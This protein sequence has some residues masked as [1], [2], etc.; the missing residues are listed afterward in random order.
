VTGP[1]HHS[2]GLTCLPYFADRA[3]DLIYFTYYQQGQQ[4]SSGY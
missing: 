2:G 4:A 1:Y 3:C